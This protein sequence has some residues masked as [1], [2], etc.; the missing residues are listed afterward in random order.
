M[1]LA[2]STTL[3]AGSVWRALPPRVRDADISQLGLKVHSRPTRGV[4]VAELWLEHQIDDRWMAA[5]RIITSGGPARV[6]EVRVFPLEP[7]FASRPVGEWSGS[8]KGVKAT[9]PRR[10]LTRAVLKQVRLHDVLKNIL[11]VQRKVEDL[12]GRQ[13]AD[14]FEQRILVDQFGFPAPPPLKGTRSRRGRPSLG[15]DF[16]A[17]VAADYVAAVQEGKPP[18]VAL[19]T[20]HNE[21]LGRVRGWVHRA[22]NRGLLVGRAQGKEGGQLSE[23]A[24]FILEKAKQSRRERRRRP[25]RRK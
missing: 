4:S 7:E 12:Y 2:P 20:Q 22:R 11:E 5:F 9:A 16:Y 6:G 17:R 3:T 21:P 24:I 18:I 15:D 1:T 19:S 8:W 13:R 25:T 23:K 14:D 10:G